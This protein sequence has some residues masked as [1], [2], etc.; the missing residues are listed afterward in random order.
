MSK[1]LRRPFQA[2]ASGC[3]TGRHLSRSVFSLGRSGPA[4]WPVNSFTTAVSID[5]MSTSGNAS[6]L[7]HQCT[8]C[9]ANGV[10]HV[11]MLPR[12]ART[13]N[14]NK[15]KFLGSSVGK[16]A[17]R[18]FSARGRAL[19]STD[20]DSPVVER[21]LRGGGHRRCGDRLLGVGGLHRL[22]LAKGFRPLD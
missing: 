21:V 2:R 19:T 5:A 8:S 3:N 22:R 6:V 11:A 1:I 12:P 10:N 14:T 9:S 18:R 16:V 13:V 15:R 20:N 17:A 7:L 4:E